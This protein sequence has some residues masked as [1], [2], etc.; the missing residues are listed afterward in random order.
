MGATTIMVIRHAEKPGD[1]DRINYDGV[2]TNGAA[3]SESLVT[4]GSM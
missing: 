4:L 3:N 1:Y 2:Q